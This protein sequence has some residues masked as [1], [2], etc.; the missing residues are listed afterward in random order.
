[1]SEEYDKNKQTTIT[2]QLPIV[3]KNAFKS[4]S[5]AEGKQIREVLCDFIEKYVNASKNEYGIK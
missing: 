4:K 3:L 1:M 2:F 5:S